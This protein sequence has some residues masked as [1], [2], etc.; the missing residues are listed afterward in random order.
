MNKRDKNFYWMSMGLNYEIE[1]KNK[2]AMNDLV[3]VEVILP[4]LLLVVIGAIIL[5]I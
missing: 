1:R 5:F 4:I 3:I 2:E